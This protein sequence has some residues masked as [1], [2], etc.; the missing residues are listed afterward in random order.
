MNDGTVTITMAKAKRTAAGSSTQHRKRTKQTS[1][2]QTKKQG[3]AKKESKRRKT[4]QLNLFGDGRGHVQRYAKE[5][6]YITKGVLLT[7]EVYGNEIPAG[8]ENKLFH[9]SV[10]AYDSDKKKFTVRYV[11][12][13]IEEDGVAWIHDPDGLRETMPNVAY[14]TIVDGHELYLNAQGCANAHE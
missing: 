9:Y 3:A 6:L 12:R 8:M 7:D 1:T 5:P 14:E 2:N 13:W 11:N 10:S 4:K